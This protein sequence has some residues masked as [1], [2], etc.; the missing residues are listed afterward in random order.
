MTTKH[1]P[2]PWTLGMGDNHT[3]LSILAPG[4]SYC[5]L[6]VARMPG[7][8]RPTDAIWRVIEADARLIAAAPDLLAALEQLAEAAAILGTFAPELVS[9]RAAIARA[10]GE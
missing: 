9:A 4:N 5:K 1:T 8:Y 6:L 2:G 3:H 10:K 7:E